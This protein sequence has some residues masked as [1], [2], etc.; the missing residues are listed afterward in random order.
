MSWGFIACINL[1]ISTFVREVSAVFLVGHWLGNGYC[2]NARGFFRFG[3]KICYDR[4]ILGG[5]LEVDARSRMKL[6]SAYEL[7]VSK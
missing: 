1:V 3:Q 4:G 2:E 7:W 5:I 6:R